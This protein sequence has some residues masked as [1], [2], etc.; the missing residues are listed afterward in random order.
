MM[1]SRQ[2]SM[3]IYRASGA[4]G[5]MVILSPGGISPLVTYTQS[6]NLTYFDSAGV[7]QTAGVNTMVKEY[8]PVTLALK[9]YPFWEARTNS[10]RNNTMVGA[11]APST[12]PT[13]WGEFTNVL[14]LTRTNTPVGTSNG[15]EYTDITI[16]GTPSGAGVYDIQFEGATQI[17]ASNGQAWSQSTYYSMSSGSTAGI[18]AF[19]NRIAFRSAV[20]ELSTGETTFTPTSSALRTQRVITSATATDALTLYA[21]P[22]IRLTLSGPAINIT[23]RI[24]LPQLERES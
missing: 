15:I 23:L 16:S 17:A 13:N 19:R 22:Y 21:L 2:L 14:G 5:G 11:S 20:A 18:S 1:L 3:S 10:I 12:L 4:G 8:D 9:G 24:G 6:G 7:L